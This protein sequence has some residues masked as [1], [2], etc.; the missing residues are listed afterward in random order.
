MEDRWFYRLDDREHGPFTLVVLQELVGSSGST[1]EQVFV[2][3]VGRTEWIPFFQLEANAE[4]ARAHRQRIES[5]P[6]ISAAFTIMPVGLSSSTK[7]TAR[8]TARPLCELLKDNRELV[9]GVLILTLINVGA[10][11]AWSDPF[12]TER[13]YFMTLRHLEDEIRTLRSR[14]ASAEE[15]RSLRAEAKRTLEP[16]VADLRRS[17]SV[18]RPIRQHLLWVARDQM[19]RLVHADAP[20]KEVERRYRNHM[21]IIEHELGAP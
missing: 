9:V 1:A 4:L 21:E 18:S 20:E 19:P 12:S 7:A 10:L 2:R 8:A 5:A 15:W 16:I 17:A 13:K 6:E 11:V 14:D 3:Q